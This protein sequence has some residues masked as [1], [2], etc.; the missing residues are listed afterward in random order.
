MLDACLYTYP[1]PR[2]RSIAEARAAL[3][4]WLRAANL[5][6]SSFAALL[7]LSQPS[8]SRWLGS[9]RP[10]TPWDEALEILTGIPRG[11]WWT[12]EEH[13]VIARARKL[14][15]SRLHDRGQA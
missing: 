11:A 4:E 10:G 9:G 7:G 2:P 15:T 3:A 8:V 1:V 13:A 12:E 14:R 6:P 5:T